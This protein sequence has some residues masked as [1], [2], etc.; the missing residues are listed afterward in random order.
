MTRLK[1]G[2]ESKETTEIGLVPPSFRYAA[3]AR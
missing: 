2:W 1:T 3:P